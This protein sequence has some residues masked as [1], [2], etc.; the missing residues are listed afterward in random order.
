V[1]FRQFEVRDADG[2]TAAERA[3]GIYGSD[4]PEIDV[5]LPPDVADIDTVGLVVD[6][7]EGLFIFP[8][9]GPVADTFTNPDLAT[10][11][12][13][14]EAVRE[15]LMEPRISPVPLRH[16]AE[17]D[18]ESASRVFQQVLRRPDFAWERDGEALL[19]QY[20]ASFFDRPALPGVTVVGSAL[21][22]ARLAPVPPRTPARPQSSRP[23]GKKK[24]TKR[25]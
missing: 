9:L 22:R 17:R 11:Q 24:R 5:Q 21:A 23:R 10:D 25:R 6:E 13:Y 19:R 16:L 14:Q 4:P 15:H 8:D 1:H 18:P 2:K 20:K 3:R 12:R 7:V